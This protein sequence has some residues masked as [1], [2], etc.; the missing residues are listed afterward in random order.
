MTE[1]FNKLKFL[2]IAVI[3]KSSHLFPSRWLSLQLEVFSLQPLQSHHNL[4]CRRFALFTRFIQQQRGEAT[5][6]SFAWGSGGDYNEHNKM[7]LMSVKGSLTTTT[8]N[9][10]REKHQIV[11]IQALSDGIIHENLILQGFLM[12]SSFLYEQKVSPSH[13][14]RVLR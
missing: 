2:S 4:S 5:T 13:S 7:M 11:W 3:L 8:T 1:I 12:L 9:L 6:T 14:D 10:E